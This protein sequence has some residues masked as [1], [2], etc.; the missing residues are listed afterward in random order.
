MIET[1]IKEVISKEFKIEISEISSDF[2][3]ENIVTW[4]SLKHL[5]LV[6]ALE[7]VFN[8]EFEPEEISNMYDLN[9]I[10]KL[11]EKKLDEKEF[12]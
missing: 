2:S 10:I 6:V 7:S 4:D 12:H 9:S 3:Q 8:T 11:V 1:Q 5:N